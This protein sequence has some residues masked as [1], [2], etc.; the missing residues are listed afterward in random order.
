VY[1]ISYWAK[2]TEIDDGNTLTIYS[3]MA[4]NYL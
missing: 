1:G 4:K 2:V 3:G